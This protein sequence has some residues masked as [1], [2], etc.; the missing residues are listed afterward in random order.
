MATRDLEARRQR[1]LRI[2]WAI[3]IALTVF[4]V[5]IVGYNLMR[6]AP[7]DSWRMPFI[8]DRHDTWKANNP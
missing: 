1:I 2:E 7:G 5:G 6:P 4:L 3:L 8:Q